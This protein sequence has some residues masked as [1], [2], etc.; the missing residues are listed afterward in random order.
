MG[1]GMPWSSAPPL[2]IITVMIG[3]MGGLQHAVNYAYTGHK[4]APHD[5]AGRHR[6]DRAMF[7][8]DLEA[9]PDWQAHKRA[10]NWYAVDRQYEAWE[11]DQKLVAMIEARR[12]VAA[13]ARS[14]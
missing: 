2:V 4:Q 14:S 12:Q 11:K 5:K 9:S 13:G 1:G 7:R 3:A 8:R 10:S 6:W